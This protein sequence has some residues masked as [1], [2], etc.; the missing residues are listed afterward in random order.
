MRKFLSMVD[1]ALLMLLFITAFSFALAI[2][3]WLV[4]IFG[5]SIWDVARTFVVMVMNLVIIYLLE[6]LISK[7]DIEE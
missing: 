7:L 2:V 3:F 5:V 4:G 1:G 6:K